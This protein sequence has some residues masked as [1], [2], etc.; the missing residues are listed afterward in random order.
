MFKEEDMEEK[1]LELRKKVQK[2]K[3]DKSFFVG[4][5]DDDMSLESAEIT[6]KTWYKAFNTEIW[7]RC[8]KEQKIVALL[9]LEGVAHI[10]QKRKPINNYK[11]D[12]A[13]KVPY[14][15]TY[16]PIN[17]ELM[18]TINPELLNRSEELSEIG[19][20]HASTLLAYGKKAKIEMLFDKV[21]TKGLNAISREDALR[22]MTIWAAK[23]GFEEHLK[24]SIEVGKLADLV[25]TGTDLMSARDQELFGIKV[26]A[27]Y[28]GGELVY[29]SPANRPS[30]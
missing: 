21:F 2:I 29:E 18:L 4:Y 1:T 26:L 24:G 22:A 6:R 15:Y 13:A 28:S 30:E 25:V 8:S 5:T 11:I 7:N 19:F 20:S 10:L 17:K 3:Q 16:N 9:W 27:T 14:E 12:N 23:S